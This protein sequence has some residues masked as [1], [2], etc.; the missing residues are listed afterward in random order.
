MVEELSTYLRG[1]HG[2]FSFCQ[3]PTVLQGLDKWLRRRLRSVLWKQWKRRRKRFPELR[4]RGIG[5]VLAAKTACSA[6]GP[7]RLAASPA[8][9]YALPNAYFDSLG[10]P[11]LVASDRLHPPNRRMRTCLSGGMAGAR[12]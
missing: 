6:H 7:W 10:L 2:Y 11:A 3:T 12:G 9:S 8:L 1:W 5:R 4:R